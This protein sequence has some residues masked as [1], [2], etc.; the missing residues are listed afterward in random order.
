MLHI[1]T[2]LR[3]MLLLLCVGPFDARAQLMRVHFIDVGQGAATLIE[4]SCAAMLVDTGGE[5]NP[6]FDSK[7]VL[8]EYLDDFFATRPDLHRTLHTLVLSHPHIDHTRGAAKILS[9]YRVLNAITNG[10][11]TGSGRHGQMA[12]HKRVAAGEES[13]T[14][15]DDIGL[16]VA[17]VRD[18]SR[19]RGLTSRVIDPIRCHGVDP[20]VTILW[21]RVD[22]SLNWTAKAMSN[23]NNHS[24]VVRVDHGKSSL[25]LAGDLEEEGI[26]AMLAHH[27]KSSLLDVDVVQVNHH[28]SANGTT[29]ELLKATRP[30][31]AVIQMGS[32]ERELLF[33]A[34]AYGHPRTK[35][36]D[37]LQ[38][39]VTKSRAATEVMVASGTR[40][41]AHYT[42]DKAIYGTGWDGTVVLQADM[43]GNWSVLD[44][45][46]GSGKVDL[47]TATMS[48]LMA[49]P[50]IGPSRA[51]AI[52]RYR[53][54]HGRIGKVDDLLKIPGIKSG[55]INALRHLVTPE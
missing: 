43:D 50:M 14:A 5:T 7:A 28:G 36:L 2:W 21:G 42:I 33:T 34:W 39:Q 38:A 17:W 44:E 29:E 54:V 27:A 52:I 15:T 55:T 22:A 35:V 9:A 41:F 24:V 12:V 13:V 25:L 49:L 37:L 51:T 23:A 47:N 16:A 30:D 46:A 19:T 4:F 40:K 8:I 1:R 20:A 11:E 53:T 45:G 48:Q 31:V 6:Q 3:L 32:Q 26:A 18:I 10:M